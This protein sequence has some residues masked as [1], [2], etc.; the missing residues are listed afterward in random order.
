MIERRFLPALDE[1]MVD[2]Y[3]T[4]FRQFGADPR[5]LGWDRRESQAVRFASAARAVSFG[6]RSVLDI[7]CGLADFGDFLYR[8]PALA[9]SKYSGID[10]NPDLIEVCC[11]R[12]PSGSFEVRNVLRQ[13][14]G[15]ERW[16][17]VTMFGLLNLRFTEFSNE[18][19]AREFIA[20]A[21]R[22]CGEAL[23]VDMLSAR[24]DAAY[25]PEDFV[26]YYQPTAMLDFALSLTPHVMLLHDYPSIPQREFMLVL[27]KNQCG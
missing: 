7:G 16:D 22:I 18:E 25:M 9:P 19:Y 2:R 20:E 26:Y 17:V 14:Y 13:P 1:R 15:E 10:I 27:R 6:G 24:T 5:T 4:R 12:H 3:S 23:V 21:F 8:N 11:Q